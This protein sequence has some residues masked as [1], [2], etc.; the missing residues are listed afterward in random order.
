MSCADKVCRWNVLG[1]Q[2]SL[3]PTTWSR[4]PA[5]C[6]PRQSVPP[7]S[8]VPGSDWPRQGNTRPP[9]RPIQTQHAEVQFD[10]QPGGEKSWQ[11]TELQ[12]QLDNWPT[13]GGGRG[14]HEGEGAGQPETEQTVQ[15]LHV[16]TVAAAGPVRPPPGKGADPT[17][18]NALLRG[19]ERQL[20]QSG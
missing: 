2:G 1:L 14:R 20:V 7:H 19:Q 5:Q 10:D 3:S 17:V 11:G 16:Q 13:G 18:C 4:V 12:R 15:V 6:R 8:H 9:A